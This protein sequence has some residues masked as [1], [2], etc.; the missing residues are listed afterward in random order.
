MI[1]LVNVS[2]YY[3]TDFGR[4]YVFR[5]VSLVLP[6]DKS[7]A[8]LG[9]NGAGKS[10]FLR[11]LGGADMPSE[12]R[13]IKTGRISPPMGLTPGIQ[14]SLTASENARFAGRI[15]GMTRDE[16]DDTI[17]YVRNLANI[18]KFFDMPVSSYSAGMK[19]RVAFAINMS[20]TFDYYLFDEI[21]AGG[22]KDFRKIT[23]AMVKERLKTSK[24]IIASHRR[25]ELLDIC[26]SGIVIQNGELTFYDDIQDALIAYGDTDDVPDKPV[27]RRNRRRN[28]DGS[29]D[30]AGDSLSVFADSE[31]APAVE[32]DPE[33]VERSRV[34]LEKLRALREIKQQKRNKRRRLVEAAQ[35][36]GAEA[37]GEQ[38]DPDQALPDADTESR[39]ERL[40]RLREERTLARQLRAHNRKAEKLLA[41]VAPPETIAQTL[42]DEISP[43]PELQDPGGIAAVAEAVNVEAGTPPPDEPASSRKRERKLAKAK[44][45]GV[46]ATPDA[47]PPLILTPPGPDTADAQDRLR[48]AFLLQESAQVK[49]A[50]AA[51]LLLQ[52]VIDRNNET[53]AAALAGRAALVA[54]AQQSAAQEAARARTLLESLLPEQDDEQPATSRKSKKKIKRTRRTARESLPAGEPHDTPVEQ[55]AATDL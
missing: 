52:H 19:Q 17:E 27:K 18:G 13:I 26:D 3:P 32:L 10:T 16:I 14:P 24:F 41:T 2:K 4:H 5:D 33:A 28:Q 36:M 54:V 49:S 50:R 47:Q 20:M 1:E 23:Q 34:Q 6:L 38:T 37:A 48:Q 44:R 31:A 45:N 40:E 12:G 51:R 39:E 53:A 29:E 35:A 21:G 42:A 15:Y 46:T 7:V 11:L 9:P 55:P 43:S 25:D 22:D 30:P 8:V